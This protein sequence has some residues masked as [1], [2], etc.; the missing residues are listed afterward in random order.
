[1]GSCDSCFNIPG[2]G[3]AVPAVLDDI[4][5]LLGVSTRSSGLL[6]RGRVWYLYLSGTESLG[7]WKEQ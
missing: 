5:A 6:S 4:S 1:V 3:E 7:F 2:L